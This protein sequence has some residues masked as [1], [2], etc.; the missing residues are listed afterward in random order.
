MF[1]LTWCGAAAG[2]GFLLSFLVG[3]VSGAGLSWALVRAL[4]FGVVFFI[5]AG[6]I[7]FLV[8][9]F[10]PDLLSAGEDGADSS[11]IPGSRV[12]ISVGDDQEAAV[13]PFALPDDSLTGEEPGDIAD[14]LNGNIVSMVPPP[15][16]PSMQGMD[17]KEEEGYTESRKPG[18]QSKVS[19]GGP[20]ADPGEKAAASEGLR[21]P[22]DLPDL[23]SMAEVFQSKE[24]EEPVSGGQSSFG[25]PGGKADRNRGKSM[26]GDFNPKDLASAIQTIL[27]KD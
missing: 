16:G 7:R 11:A 25:G 22:E 18:F 19:G 23:D 20:G 8:D 13:L 10:L 3:I 1:S 27:S 24:N 6:I 12:D 4:F 14:L 9:H 5:L 2:L 17:Q 26:A 21:S 15:P